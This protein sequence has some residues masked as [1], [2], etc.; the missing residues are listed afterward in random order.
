MSVGVTI[1][2]YYPAAGVNDAPS[3]STFAMT[4]VNEK[5]VPVMT[6]AGKNC[7]R[8]KWCRKTFRTEANTSCDL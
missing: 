1:M 7:T 3:R 5:L 4:C 2:P 8:L 6:M